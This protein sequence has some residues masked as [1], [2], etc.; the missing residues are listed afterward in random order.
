[1][2]KEC[3]CK[4]LSSRCEGKKT[5]ALCAPSQLFEE[6]RM[7]AVSG[8]C[9]N[10]DNTNILPLGVSYFLPTVARGAMDDFQG[11]GTA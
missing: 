1:M 11:L 8:D 2:D 4:A 9:I 10:W 6:M 3:F 5:C 7:S